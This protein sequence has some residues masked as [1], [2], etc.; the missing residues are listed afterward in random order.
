MSL[1]H[2]DRQ[3]LRDLE[4]LR[5]HHPTAIPGSNNE[6]NLQRF[7][8][9][10]NWETI[11]PRIAIERERMITR[12]HSSLSILDPLLITVVVNS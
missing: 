4:L 7:S 5:L 10:H 3:N 11:A 8:C 6:G 2:I 12:Y 9:F 1:F